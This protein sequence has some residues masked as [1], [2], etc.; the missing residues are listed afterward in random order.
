MNEA[1]KEEFTYVY[2]NKDLEQIGKA[3]KENTTVMRSFLAKIEALMPPPKYK[4]IEYTTDDT[5]N[6]PTTH[7]LKAKE[8]VI[9]E[10]ATTKTTE[11]ITKTPLV[12]ENV[13]LE[14]ETEKAYLLLSGNNKAW[15]PKKAIEDMN[16]NAD[17]Y[18][19]ITI[20]H[21]FKD[22]ISWLQEDT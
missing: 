14:I 13:Q 8:R 18:G 21:W 16:V 17:N 11:K 9:H 1:E 6:Q 20:A 22:K 7:I 5:T 12:L 2:I 4:H 3:I 15:V 10:D 19:T